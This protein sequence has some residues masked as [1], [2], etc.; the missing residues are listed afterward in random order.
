MSVLIWPQTV[1]KGYQQ[2][3]KVASSREKLHT[4]PNILTIPF[5]SMI[6]C[7]KGSDW[8]ALSVNPVFD[9]YVLLNIRVYTVIY[10]IVLHVGLL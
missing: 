7:V 9:Q 5:Y 2:T 3:T 4:Y 6:G 1:R 10:N 8:L